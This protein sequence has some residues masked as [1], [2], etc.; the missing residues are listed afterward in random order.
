MSIPA[1]PRPEAAG[2]TPAG[3]KITYLATCAGSGGSMSGRFSHSGLEW[4][5]GF[6]SAHLRLIAKPNAALM[7]LC[8]RLTVLAAIGPTR[9]RQ[10]SRYGAVVARVRAAEP[11][12]WCSMTGRP[13]TSGWVTRDLHNVVRRQMGM[14][15]G[16]RDV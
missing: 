13:C 9:M 5:A 3:A 7:L 1:Q 12:G 15:I 2:T 16:S 10:A 6:R 8:I 11:S 4:S 14:R